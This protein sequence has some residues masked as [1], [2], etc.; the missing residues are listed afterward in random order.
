[1][2]T[3]LDSNEQFRLAKDGGIPIY[4]ASIILAEHSRIELL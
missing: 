4:Y 2:L 1:M 3:Q